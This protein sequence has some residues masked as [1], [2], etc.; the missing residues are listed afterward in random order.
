MSPSREV[1]GLPLARGLF[2]PL[3][4]SD[5][6]ACL[7]FCVTGYQSSGVARDHS[8]EFSSV[9]A[10]SWRRDMTPRRK[11]RPERPNRVIAHYAR[12]QLT[13]PPR[14]NSLWV[15]TAW[16]ANC[17][18]AGRRLAAGSYVM[19]YDGAL[20]PTPWDSAALSLDFAAPSPLMLSLAGGNVAPIPT[21]AGAEKQNKR[22]MM[23]LDKHTTPDEP[24]LDLDALIPPR[25]RYDKRTHLPVESAPKGEPKTN[26]ATPD[27]LISMWMA[28]CKGKMEPQPG[29]ARGGHRV[30]PTTVEHEGKSSPDSSS[31]WPPRQ[32]NLNSIGPDQNA[33][34]VT[35]LHVFFAL[36][37]LFRG[38]CT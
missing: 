19:D 4:S 22:P 13:S 8:G 14:R 25:V 21:V 16:S 33:R 27:R 17:P 32:I 11:P 26:P 3:A 5:N 12:R 29:Q 7:G 28:K 36:P 2:G 34:P 38:I 31:S 20:L 1:L 23:H 24:Q 30:V 35:K 6:D 9:W 18:G 15:N 10:A 37:R